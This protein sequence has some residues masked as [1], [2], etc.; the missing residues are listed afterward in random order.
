MRLIPTVLRIVC[1]LVI[2]LL[3][4][5]GSSQAA[6]FSARSPRN[7]G[8]LVIIDPGH[9]GKDPGAHSRLGLL[10]KKLALTIA[11]DL[12]D[13]LLRQGAGVRVVMTRQSDRF[14]DL[15][16]R[17]QL[18]NDGHAALFVSIHCDSHPATA[19]RGYSI[20]YAR[21]GGTKSALAARTIARRMTAA[22]L[23]QRTV[24]RDYRGLEVLDGTAGPA[25]LIETGFLSNPREAARLSDPRYQHKL[26]DAMA[27]GI[28][29]YLPKSR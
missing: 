25:V 17:V 13:S 26:A 23:T 20:L 15:D 27:Q 6:S 8:L 3:A 21:A 18:A 5:S 10:E 2:A 19:M 22:G 24:R 9:G 28:L 14:V 16:R 4:L 12:A 29:D 11:T 7:S 1:I